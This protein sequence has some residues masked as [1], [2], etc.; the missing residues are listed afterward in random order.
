MDE[1]L[2]PGQLFDIKAQTWN[3]IVDAK[4]FIL[5]YKGVIQALAKLK[6]P[7][8]PIPTDVIT[9][10]N[11]SGADWAAG[12]VA[13]LGVILFDRVLRTEIG[14]KAD[15]VSHAGGRSYC[16]LAKPLPDGGIGPAHISGVCVAR[17]NVISTDDRFAF[18]ETSSHV[19]K[20]GKAGPWKLLGPIT[21]TGEKDVVVCFAAPE[22][23]WARL[24]A[25]LSAGGSATA[26]I[27][28]DIAGTMTDSGLDITVYDRLMEIGGSLPVKTR[29]RWGF[30]SG[31]LYV[32]NATCSPDTSDDVWGE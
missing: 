27:W 4:D 6:L 24:T 9:V 8:A 16:I 5:K 25:T 15:T 23:G 22:W 2:R 17:V 11:I 13:E 21:A 19:L 32:L 10:K 18:A 30:D 1:K 26:R 14:F 3:E 7:T 20:T 29:I 28:K 31:K 12:S